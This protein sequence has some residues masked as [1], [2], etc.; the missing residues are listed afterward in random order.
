MEKCLVLV[1]A[2]AVPRDTLKNLDC[3]HELVFFSSK[4]SC[5]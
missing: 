1:V 5:T 3:G 2:I 4:F